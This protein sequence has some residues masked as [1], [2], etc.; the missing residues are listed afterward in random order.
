[1]QQAGRSRVEFRRGH[2]MTLGS[3]QPLTEMSTRILRGGIV[4]GRV[5]LTTSPSIVSRL[6]RKCRSLDVSEPYGPPRSVA[7]IILPFFN[8]YSF[9]LERN[10]PRIFG[11]KKFTEK[12][13]Y[14]KSYILYSSVSITVYK[15]IK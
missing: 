2:W 12:R 14:K 11:V 15:I 10:S 9:Y 1:M 6:S 4:D 3:T 13:G 7:R 8:M 5:R